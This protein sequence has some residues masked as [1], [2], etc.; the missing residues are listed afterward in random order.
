[1]VVELG[2]LALASEPVACSLGGVVPV[3]VPAWAFS[4]VA[5]PVLALEGGGVA[6]P[7]AG[8]C[9][10]VPA[11]QVSEIICTLETLNAFWF[12]AALVPADGLLVLGWFSAVPEV[13]P[14][15]LDMVPVTWIS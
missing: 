12:A 2:L 5:A 9:A 8:G 14:E 3:A 11:V 13:L 7:P 4:P 15:A 6:D 10:P 1:M